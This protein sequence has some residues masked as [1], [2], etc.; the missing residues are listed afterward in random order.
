MNILMGITGSIAAFKAIELSRL[1]LKRGHRVIPV[2]TQSALKFV[3]PLSL[4]S[5]LNEKVYYDMFE[6]NENKT[7]I[8]IRLARE[9]DLVAIIPATF[10]FITKASVGLADDLL[11]LV[12]HSANLPKIV[13]P[14]MH[15]TL[16]QNEILQNHLLNLERMGVFIIEP[17]EGEMSDLTVGKG[18][19]KEPVELLKEIESYIELINRLKGKKILLTFGRTEEEIDDVRVIT[20]RSSGKMGL[21]LYKVLKIAG[22]NLKVFAGKTDFEI[23]PDV[24]RL[25]STL[26]FLENL[27][28]ELIKGEYDALIMC[29][30]LSDFRPK[31]KFEGKI[32]KNRRKLKIELEENPDVLKSLSSLKKKTKLIGFALEEKPDVEV[33]YKKLREKNLDVII[34]NTIKTI[35]SDNIDF[36]I[37]NKN[38][39]VIDEGELSKMKAAFRIVKKI[40]ELLSQ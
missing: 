40:S 24:I 27:K 34:L 14:C 30:A 29:A 33:A 15:P 26:E 4:T 20:N 25:N 3:T 23:P 19:L 6:E 18:R 31:K 39:E 2:L 16:Y 35:S 12:F 13:A 7:P 22:A 11:S 21:S 10:N 28:G 37:I 36:K 1:L 38:K 5:L 17:V 9:C 32:K 8:H